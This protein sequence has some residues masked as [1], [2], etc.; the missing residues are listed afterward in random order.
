[1]FH[2]GQIDLRAILRQNLNLFS[3]HIFLYQTGKWFTN[4]CKMLVPFWNL[5]LKIGRTREVGHLCWL[6]DTTQMCCII[7]IGLGNWFSQI[8]NICELFEKWLH[9]F[10]KLDRGGEP[11]PCV[12]FWNYRWHYYCNCSIWY[13]NGTISRLFSDVFFHITV[14]FF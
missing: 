12:W 13:I 1:M 2:L 3:D 7:Y 10:I 6:N 4:T 9:I 14:F 11:T 5:Y 8:V